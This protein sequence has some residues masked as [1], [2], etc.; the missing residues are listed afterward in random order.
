MVVSQRVRS[1]LYV[2]GDRPD[3]FDKAAASGADAIIIDLEDAVRES[4]KV[5]ARRNAGAWLD[6]NPEA[7]AW[8][9]VNN[10]PDVLADDLAMARDC[11]PLGIVM[12]KADAESC[13][14]DGVAV[15]ALVESAAGVADVDE[16]AALPAVVR[17]AVGEADLCADLG[18]DPSDDAR[19][20]WPVRS[21]VVVAS[22]AA[23]LPG[24]TGPVFTNLDDPDGLRTTSEA[25]RRQGFT[26]RSAIH[27]DQV[28]IINEVFSPSDEEVAWATSVVAAHEASGGGGAV[29]DGEFFDAAVVR[30]ARS[31]LARA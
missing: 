9:R 26:G 27:P 23:G 24:P 2:P 14:Q 13:D 16:I 7:R 21:R 5:E 22:A 25:L 28:P 11:A 19:E 12:P 8:V 18:L 29:V 10:R 31:I 20:M 30:R 4:A 17:V 6:A 3:R 15:L 1:T